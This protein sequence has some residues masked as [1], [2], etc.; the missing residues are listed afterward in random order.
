MKAKLTYYELTNLLKRQI[1]RDVKFEYVNNSTFRVSYLVKL[2]FVAKSLSINLKIDS[3]NNHIIK[4]SM[5]NTGIQK[6]ALKGLLM[7]FSFNYIR[8]NHTDK[9]ISI[10]TYQI[11][12]CRK[13]YEYTSIDAVFFDTDG[14]NVQITLK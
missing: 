12:Q 9:T 2:A 3:I 13:L 4:L 8:Y 10:D 1:N 14:V 11:D 5:P 6:M 7:I